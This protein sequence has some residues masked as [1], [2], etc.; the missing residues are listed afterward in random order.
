[1]TNVEPNIDRGE[2]KIVS[3]RIQER[4]LLVLRSTR[5]VPF[6]GQGETRC[7]R[8]PTRTDLIRGAS[9]LSFA[10]SSVWPVAMGTGEPTMAGR[11]GYRHK[12]GAAWR[13]SPLYSGGRWA[14]RRVC[15]FSPLSFA[16]FPPTPQ[17]ALE[18]VVRDRSPSRGQRAI[19]R[20]YRGRPPEF[21]KPTCATARASARE[22][23]V[24]PERARG[25]IL[26]REW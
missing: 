13:R 14:E 10:L 17:H 3:S 20:D 4:I 18:T 8:F 1:M 2:K 6:K 5:R 26:P 16:L 23:Y 7:P 9:T 22:Q 21:V 12:S 24:S 25:R 19:E 11:G 15:N